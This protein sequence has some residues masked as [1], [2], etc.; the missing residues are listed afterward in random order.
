M[1]L[2]KRPRRLMLEPLERREMLAIDVAMFNDH[3]AGPQTH[4]NAT[5]FSGNGTS[6]GFL[7]DIATGAPTDI[8]L[9]VSGSGVSYENTSGVPAAGTDAASIFGGF[10]DFSSG[11]GSSLAVAGS[12]SYTHAFSG[13]DPANRYDFAGTAVRG[14]TGYT[15]RWTLVTLVGAASFTAA[16]S[17]GVGIVTAGL[18]P[19][20]AALWTGENHLAAQG[21]VVAWTD[22]DPGPDGQFQIVSTQYQGPTP[23]VGTGNS[24][25]G[26]KGYA[27]AGVRLVEHDASFRVLASTPAAGALVFPAPASI[28]IDFS[29]A[30]DATSVQAS[31]LTADGAAAS[32]Y[33]LVDADSVTFH[34]AAP[35]AAGTRTVSMAA[36]AVNGPASL[37][38]LPFTAS[39]TVLA[40]AAVNNVA[41]Q[42]ITAESAT[43]GAQVTSTGGDAPALSIVW[44]TADRGANAAAWANRIDFGPSGVG[45]YQ[46]TVTGLAPQTQYFYRALAANGAGETWASTAASF[47]TNAAALPAIDNL[48]ATNV[49]ALSA[50]LRGRVTNTGGQ[51][52]QVTLYY[53]D[54][55]AGDGSA[56]AWDHAVA[57]GA[58]AGNFAHFVTGLAAETT[59]YYRA[60]ATNDAGSVWAT[61][62]LSFTTTADVP[63]SVVINE[64]HYDH[65]VKTEPVEFVE[66]YNAGAD[67]AD[68]S[69]WYFSSG[70]DYTFPPGTVLAAGGYLVVSQSPAALQ[71]KYGAASLGP[72]VGNLASDGETIRLRNAAGVVQDEVDYKLGFPWPTVGEAPGYSIELV[73]P[74]LD[75]NLGG[76]WRSSRGAAASG[77]LLFDSG[78]AWRYFKGTQEPSGGTATW[79]TAAFDD[80]QWSTGVASIGYGDPFVVT[81]LADMQNGYSTVYL[82]K[83]FNVADPNAFADLVL[84]A[85]FDDGVNVWVN[86]NYFGGANVSGENLPFNGTATGSAEDASFRPIAPANTTGFLVPGENVVAVQLLNSSLAGSSDAWFDARLVGGNAGAGPTPGERNSV[87]AA[88]AAPQMRQI[89]HTPD[90]PASGEV[91]AVTAKVTDPD[92]VDGV[93]LEYQVVLPGDYIELG[94]PRYATEWTAVAMNDAGTNGDAV[95]GDDVFT[96][97]LPDAIQQHRNL[98]R[99]RVTATDTLGASIRGPYDDDPTPN[100]AY[101]VYDGIPTWNGAIQ[102]GSIDPARNTPVAYDANTLSRAAT[103]HLITT[104]SDHVESQH[105]PNA[106]TAGYGGDSYL[107]NGTL[108]YDGKVYDHINYRARGGVWRYAMG[109]N[110]WKFDFQRGH[111]FQARDAYGREYDTDWTKLNLG[112]NIQQGDFQQRGEQGLFEGVGFRLFNLAG[113]PSSN[114]HYVH[115]RIIDRAAETGATQ[116][117]TDFQGLYL[118]VEQLDGRFLD[119]H[120]LPD[121]NLYKMEGGTGEAN[122]IGPAGPTD[123]SDLNSFIG[124]YSGSTQTDAWWRANLDLDKYY[125]YRAMVEATH[126]WDIGFG[127]NYFYY[128]NPETGQWSPHAWDLDLTWTTTYEPGCGDCEPFK[129]H[130]LSRPAFLLEYRNVLR[131][132][133]DLLWNPEQVGK[134]LDEHAAFVDTPAGGASLVDA[135]RAMWDYNPILASSYVNGSKAGHGRFYQSASPQTFAGM[136]QKLKNYVATRSAYIDNS[137]IT[138]ADEAAAPRRPTATYTGPV[139]APQNALAFSASAFAAGNTAAPFAKMEWRVAEITN[140]A[141]PAYDPTDPIRYEIESAWESGELTAFGSAIIVPGGVVEPGHTYRLRVRMQD[142]TGRWSHWSTPVEF[143]PTPAVSPLKITEIM[144]HPADQTPAEFAAAGVAYDAEEY[145]FIEF[146]NAGTAPLDLAGYRLANGVELTIAAGTLAPGEYAVVVRNADAFANRYGTTPRVLGVWGGTPEDYRLSN[147]GETIEL[148]DAG[149][150]VLYDFAYDDANGW[151]TAADGSGP[152]LVIVNPALDASAWS[153]PS[154]WRAS[155]TVGGSPGSTDDLPGDVNADGRVDLVDAA[156]VQQHLGTTNGATLAIG[157]ANRDGAVNRT[158]AAFVARNFGRGVPTPGASAA[159]AVL[160]RREQPPTT[161]IRAVSR[162]EQTALAANR[163]AAIDALFGDRPSETGPLAT[164]RTNRTTSARRSGQAA[165]DFTSK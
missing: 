133:R 116:Y 79:R 9:S 97:M 15:N 160:A 132:L 55:D 153:L 45:T 67:P 35:L 86:G 150:A 146:H 121:G 124:A 14:N 53:G 13:L 98:V 6:S 24:T 151:P 135:D 158:D 31:D 104:R 43:L 76:S 27:L 3:V 65:D 37:G 95:A 58:Q 52:P 20:Q 105:I 8:T 59:Y 157:D 40:P 21:F 108:V 107:W 140:P 113:S 46:R 68:L 38:M 28:T 49:A 165:F 162:R 87:H 1:L 41:A 84:E 12:Q 127:K 88:N 34:F 22:I 16:H 18:Q 115:F 122:N 155:Y 126:H 96:V 99:Y 10:V 17:A 44:D 71:T 129:S 80:L 77:G 56:T 73:H 63:L 23:G 61:P 32:S 159:R 102:P 48:P 154:S 25:G 60:G 125:A 36:G 7:K 78:E 128:R 110:M 29:D 111:D 163:R 51:T 109:K 100:F 148:V 131:E 2:E 66:L 141:A 142:T 114:T 47:S 26:G 81:N 93:V 138:A 42:G 94:D 69:L 50:T 123:K 152:S 136:V 130:I 19:N 11:A 134:M 119:E 39:F 33:T 70:I 4:I 137:L 75:N 118:A 147:G 112:A 156:I 92:G 120:D 64:I 72:Y 143:T 144:Y 139:G 57:L 90:Q 85:Q 106:A 161:E 54:D 103:Y 91:V 149:G 82:R 30:V 117:D 5:S 62:T 164:H 74:A 83:K 89:T 145:E 101:F